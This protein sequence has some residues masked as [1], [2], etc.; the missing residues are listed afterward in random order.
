MGIT[1]RHK[2]CFERLDVPI[3]TPFLLV[4]PL[5]PYGFNPF[6]KVYKFPDFVD[7]HRVHFNFH[8]VKPKVWFRTSHRLAIGNRIIHVGDGY[9]RVSIRHVPVRLLSSPPTTSKY[10]LTRF[11]W[12]RLCFSWGKNSSYRWGRSFLTQL[13]FKHNFASRF[14]ILHKVLLKETSIRANESLIVLGTIESKTFGFLR[15]SYKQAQFWPTSQLA[16]L[17][18]QHVCRATP[19]SDAAK[20]HFTASPSFIRSTRNRFGRNLVQNVSGCF[21]GISPKGK[22]EW[23]VTHHWSNHLHKSSVSSLWHSVLLRCARCGKLRSDTFFFKKVIELSRHILTTS[24]RSKGF[25]HFASLL[26]H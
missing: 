18:P 13:F 8:G 7:I 21:E 3:R 5:T 14:R 16:S 19:N 25:D 26:F 1:L 23:W 24:I 20:I 4:Y 10:Y 11:W 9:K 22:R 6:R 2:S 15:I 12:V 17:L